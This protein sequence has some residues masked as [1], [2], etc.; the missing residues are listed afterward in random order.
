MDQKPKPYAGVLAEKPPSI[1]EQQSKAL[2][3]SHPQKADTTLEAGWICCG[4]GV[5]TFWIYGIGMIF[6]L[7]AFFLGAY[8][9]ATNR[10]KT[11]LPLMIGTFVIILVCSKILDSMLASFVEDQL[12]IF[13]RETPPGR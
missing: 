9:M 6:F 11:G 1:W 10:I 2:S 7:P 3:H 13:F 8:Q 12:P 5:L 4:L